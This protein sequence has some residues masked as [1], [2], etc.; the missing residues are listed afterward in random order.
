MERSIVY[1]DSKWN[2]W[3]L[4]PW[5]PM[6]DDRWLDMW[7]PQEVPEEVVNKIKTLEKN[8]QQEMNRL[9]SSYLP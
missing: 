2:H 4:Y 7:S 8:V 9:L 5:V 1:K 6:T 3:L